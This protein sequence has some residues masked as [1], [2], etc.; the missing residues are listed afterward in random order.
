M[1][2]NKSL[3]RRVR[4]RMS[5]TGERYTTARHQ[6]LARQ[7]PPPSTPVRGDLGPAEETLR[8]RTGRGWGEWVALLDAWGAT[9]QTH[10]AIARWLHE[11][12]GVDGW[13]AQSITVGYERATGRRAPGQVA[14]GFSVSAS[15]TIGVPVEQLY[16]AFI[17]EA[18]RARW[19]GNITLHQR[20]ATPHRIARFDWEGGPSRVAVFFAAK[21]DAKSLVTV[22]HE[23]LPS[24]GEADRMKAFW[25]ERVQVLQRL[26]EAA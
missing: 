21:G 4:A 11:E 14:G 13:W 7:A 15:K 20:T 5:K 8:A 23:R 24:A 3:K 17:D 18:Q 12:H 26:L 2:E 25:R 1:T 9:Q 19:A 10:T 16:Q 22:Q 6:L